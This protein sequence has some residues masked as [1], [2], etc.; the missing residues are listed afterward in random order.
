MSAYMENRCPPTGIPPVRPQGEHL[1]TYKEFPL[2][3]D[4]ALLSARCAHIAPAAKQAKGKLRRHRRLT[5]LSILLLWLRPAGPIP[6]A[7]LLGR[8][9][10][11]FLR[12]GRSLL[13]LVRWLFGACS[14][15]RSPA[16]P[17]DDRAWRTIHYLAYPAIGVLLIHSLLGSDRRQLAGWGTVA[18]VGMIGYAIYLRQPHVGITLPSVS[19]ANIPRKVPFMPASC[20]PHQQITWSGT[21]VSGHDI[22]PVDGHGSARWRSRELPAGGHQFCFSD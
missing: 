8:G 2:S 17:E 9:T 21:S 10:L 19:T 5:E 6:R 7:A 4:T 20:H 22:L 14:S 16:Q 15:S 1:S 13:V 12:Y 3:L 18:V 11:R